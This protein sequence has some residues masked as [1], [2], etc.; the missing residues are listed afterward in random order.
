MTNTAAPEGDAA[1]GDVFGLYAAYYD[2]LYRDKDYASEA[3]FAHGLLQHGAAGRMA[4][5][6]R[7]RTLLDLGCGTGA[8]AE[9]LARLGWQVHGIDRSEGMLADAERRRAGLEPALRERLSFS[10]GDVRTVRVGTRFDAVVSLFHVAS[11]QTTNEALQALFETARCHLRPGG[12]FLFDAWY[13]P[14]VLTDPPVVR[15]KRM[16]DERVQVTRLAEPV[17]HASRNVVDVRYEVQI[18]DR[19][20]GAV[21][22]LHEV[23][24]M[25]YLFKPEVELM[26]GSCG[27]VPVA[28]GA[29]MTGQD[30][31]TQSWNVWFSARLP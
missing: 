15:V 13:G 5:T 21:Q 4:G 27:F 31:G 28:S 16:H 8:H 9:A 10:L 20:T 14:A 18:R 30:A 22:T 29:W 7:T 6:E 1:S 23:H 12:L 17:L 25:R 2:L 26:L 19:A 11:Y 24:E 3:A